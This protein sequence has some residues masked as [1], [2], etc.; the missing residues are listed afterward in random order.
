MTAEHAPQIACSGASEAFYAAVY[1]RIGVKNC[2]TFYWSKRGS[3]VLPAAGEDNGGRVY[4]QGA[5][6]PVINLLFT[7]CLLST[8]Q[9]LYPA[10]SPNSGSFT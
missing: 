2:C 3:A 5:Q 1:C 9:N 10:L 6:L 4:L 7:F 8:D